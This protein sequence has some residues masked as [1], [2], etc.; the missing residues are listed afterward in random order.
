MITKEISE[1]G[2]SMGK[3]DEILRMLFETWYFTPLGTRTGQ[4]GFVS[5][6]KWLTKKFS[7]KKIIELQSLFG[8]KTD[9][10][11]ARDVSFESNLINSC[12]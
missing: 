4:V 2:S 3:E 6:N 10:G 5:I 1:V 9:T 7:T 11:M 12:I 8:N